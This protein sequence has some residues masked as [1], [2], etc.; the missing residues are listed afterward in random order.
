MLKSKIN[1]KIYIKMYNNIGI[2]RI[3]IY[4]INKKWS[5]SI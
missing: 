1:K 3:R 2:N 5:I 4:I